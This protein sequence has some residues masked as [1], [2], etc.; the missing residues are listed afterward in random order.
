MPNHEK[1]SLNPVM[2]CRAPEHCENTHW[3]Y[4]PDG[5]TLAPYFDKRIALFFVTAQGFDL[6]EF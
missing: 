4:H 6:N 3:V 5:R 2:E 1:Q